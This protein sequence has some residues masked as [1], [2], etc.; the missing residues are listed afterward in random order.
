[1]AK[2][3]SVEVLIWSLMLFRFWRS[4]VLRPAEHYENILLERTGTRKSLGILALRKV[5]QRNFLSLT[6]LYETRLK[7]DWASRMKSKLGFIGGVHIDS[8]R[9]SEVQL[10]L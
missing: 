6:F 7:R 10:L 3:I 8:V 1:M 5:L 2:N 4:L 9:N